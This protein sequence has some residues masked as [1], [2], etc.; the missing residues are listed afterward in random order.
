LR[1]EIASQGALIE[2][3]RRIEASLSF[4]AESERAVLQQ[5]IKAMQQKMTMTETKLTTSLENA[6]S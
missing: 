2:S 3:V 4:R 5:E 1:T 6:T